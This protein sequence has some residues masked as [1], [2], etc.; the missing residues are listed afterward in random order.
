MS[1]T[2]AKLTEAAALVG[3]Q[4]EKTPGGRYSFTRNGEEVGRAT[5]LTAAADFVESQ[6]RDTKTIPADVVARYQ[7]MKN[8]PERAALLRE[9]CQKFG[10]G[11]A[12]YQQLG[13]SQIYAIRQLNALQLIETSTVIANVVNQGFLS[14]AKLNSEVATKMLQ[15]LDRQEA[16]ALGVAQQFEMNKAA[17]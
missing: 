2:F 9:C 14:W 4:V 7:A 17:A 10:R 3:L 8:S 13:I 12:T 5:T 15:G 1:D 6:A 16:I 11:Q